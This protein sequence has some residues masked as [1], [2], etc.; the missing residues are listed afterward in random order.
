MY[1]FGGNVTLTNSTI[2]GNTAPAGAGGGVFN[3]YYGSL[4]LIRTLVSGNSARRDKELHNDATA[5]V[6]ADNFNLFGH[7]GVAGVVGFS[8]G[9]TDL[10]PSGPISSILNP[11]LA[12]NGGPTR[13]HALVFGSPAVDAAPNAGCPAQDQR[14]IA[15]PVDGDGMG[16]PQ[17]DVGAFEFVS[18]GPPPPPGG[19]LNHFLCYTVKSSL[20]NTCADGSPN[21]GAAC[22]TEAT[23]GGTEDVTAFCTPNK[24]PTGVQVTLTDQFETNLF[25]V[26]KPTSLCNPANKNGEDP[27]AV[28]DPEHLEAYQITEAKGRPKHV[29]RTDLTVTNQFGS[30]QLDTIKPSRLLVPTAKSRTGPVPEPVPTIDHFECYTVR[31]STGAPKFPKDV[32]ATVVD[33][34]DRPTRYDVVN[35]TRLCAPADKNGESPGAADHPEHLLCYGVKPAKG[36]PKHV[37]VLN[38]HVNNQFGPERLDTINAEE[39]C[40]PSTKT[41]PE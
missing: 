20:G 10:V 8:P 26:Q 11:T 15:R 29:K 40:V 16:G 21:E 28:T 19:S 3:H 5:A 23:C 30:L 34:F 31:I 6:V 33:Q 1:S 18:S 24:F 9:D 32:Q 36:Q 4:T 13:T 35:P 7:S 2:S 17:C 14:G 27:S 25:D 37:K 38:L 22:T 39:L 41:L 12:D